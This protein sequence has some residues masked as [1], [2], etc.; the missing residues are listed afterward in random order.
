MCGIAGYFQLNEPAPPDKELVGRMIAAIRYRGPD[1]LGMYASDRCVLGQARLSIIDLAGGSQ[2]LGNE[3]GSV[4]VTFNGEIYN[5]VELREDLLKRGHKFRT[6]SDTE[7]IVHA[8][9]EYGRDCLEHFNGQFAFAIYDRR[10]NKLLL[11]R[12]RLGIRPA[13]YAQHDG[14]FYFASEIKS[15][16]CDP[17]MPRR[18][19]HKGLDETF[20]WWTSAPPRTLFECINELEAGTFV[21]ISHSEPNLWYG[22]EVSICIISAASL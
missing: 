21:E 5:Y 19:D 10:S 12:D 8:Y 13:F 22:N 4:W 9:E 7:V 11:A 3:D 16:F 18:L 1:E 2:P 14:R 6:R 17:T 20:T 15:I